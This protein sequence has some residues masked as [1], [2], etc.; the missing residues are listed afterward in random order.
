M[1]IIIFLF[2]FKRS[3]FCSPMLHLFDTVKKNYFEILLQMK[4]VV[5]LNMFVKI[6]IHF[7]LDSFMN[8]KFKI[9]AFI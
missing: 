8:I 6:V 4:I 3:P 7:F 1:I 9:T 5:L 2:V